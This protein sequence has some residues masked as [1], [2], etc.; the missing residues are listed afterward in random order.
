[1]HEGKEEIYYFFSHCLLCDIY[2]RGTSYII[3]EK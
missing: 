1:M 2:K 3:I